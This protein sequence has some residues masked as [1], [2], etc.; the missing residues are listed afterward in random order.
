MRDRLRRPWAGPLRP[1]AAG[2]W[3]TVLLA[4]V[5]GGGTGL[6]VHHAGAAT[7]RATAGSPLPRP[8]LTAPVPTATPAPRVPTPVRAELRSSPR[9]VLQRLAD[10]R[11]RAYR[12]ADVTLLDGADVAGSPSRARHE[13]RLRQAVAAGATYDGLRYVVREATL[14]QLRG[15]E[16]TLLA[17]V[18]TSAHTVV[19][20]D[21]SRDDRAATAGA[22]VTIELRWTSAGWRIYQ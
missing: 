9:A 15:D 13:Q 4:V 7:P 1:V 2:A 3:L 21:G 20:R 11:A 22:P 17:R 14:S 8:P 12:A 10:A 5:L 18:D 16:A 19:G 6:W